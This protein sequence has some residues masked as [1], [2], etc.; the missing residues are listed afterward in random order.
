MDITKEI[1]AV[2]TPDNFE[3]TRAIVVTAIAEILVGVW[4]YRKIENNEAIQNKIALFV[5]D[6][7]LELFVHIPIPRLQNKICSYRLGEKDIDFMSKK[8]YNIFNGE[9]FVKEIK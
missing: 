8:G 1:I 2:V 5:E 6:Y 3:T 4:V 7:I 9:R